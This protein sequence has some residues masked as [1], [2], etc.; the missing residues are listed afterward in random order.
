M[1]YTDNEVISMLEVLIDNIHVLVEFG[2]HIFQLIIGI[3][4]RTNCA[5]LLVDL[6]IYTYE[7]VYMTY[8][9]RPKQK[10]DRN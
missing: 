10:N 5:P 1:F 7:A 3:L 2:A 9:Q 8:F 6:F 4:M